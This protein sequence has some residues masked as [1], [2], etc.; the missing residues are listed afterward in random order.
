MNNL[1]RLAYSY[2]SRARQLRALAAKDSSP[3]NAEILLTVADNYDEKAAAA[4]AIEQTHHSFLKNEVDTPQTA[5][6]LS[7][8]P[9]WGGDTDRVGKRHI[10]VLCRSV[11]ES[12][13]R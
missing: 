9:I 1:L 5:I 13:R 11:D 7:A 12:I 6:E 10:A 8:S 4:E 2:R 3:R